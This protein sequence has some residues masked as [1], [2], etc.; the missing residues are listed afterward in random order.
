MGKLV[1]SLA[2]WGTAHAQ[3]FRKFALHEPFARQELAIQDQVAKMINH[4]LLERSVCQGWP[5]SRFLWHLEAI[6]PVHKWDMI[7]NIRY[8]WLIV[9]F[10][11]GREL[12]HNW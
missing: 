1:Q 11:C 12:F 8:I 7:S 6:I 10:A 5:V 2:D 3:S 4:D 9:N